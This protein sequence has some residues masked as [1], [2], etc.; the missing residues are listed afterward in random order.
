MDLEEESDGADT[1]TT[2][3]NEVDVDSDFDIHDVERQ[4]AQ[5]FLE[6]FWKGVDTQIGKLA[7]SCLLP[8]FLA[9]LILYR[10]SPC[11]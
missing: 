1:V 5:M 3:S 4:P 7:V 9:L 2:V 6:P 11:P 10:M 8:V